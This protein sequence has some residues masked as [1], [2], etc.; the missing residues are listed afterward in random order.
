MKCI[1]DIYKDVEDEEGVWKDK[2]KKD[3]GEVT[4]I[5]KAIE[6]IC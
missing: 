4:E 5:E 1:M 6:K 2:V 3:L